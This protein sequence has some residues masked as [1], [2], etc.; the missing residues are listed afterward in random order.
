MQ[1]RQLS[2]RLKS[3]IKETEAIETVAET[4]KPRDL[5]TLTLGVARNGV[6]LN[7]RWNFRPD[8]NHGDI[9]NTDYLFEYIMDATEEISTDNTF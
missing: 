3:P 9:V 7:W 1:S 5:T 8:I 2:V 6:H 4:E